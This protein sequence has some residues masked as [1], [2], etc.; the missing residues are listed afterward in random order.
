MTTSRFQ[1][2]DLL[3]APSGF[4]YPQTVRFQDIDAAGIVFF[5]RIFEYCHDAYVAFLAHAG[6]PLPAVL[7]TRAWAAPL[8]H[9]EADFLRPLR[10]GDELRVQ[11]VA[12]ELTGSTLR[13]GYRLALAALRTSSSTGTQ[14]SGEVV[15]VAQTEHVFVAPKT[16]QRI[17]PPPRISDV[18]ARLWPPR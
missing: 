5:S 4:T 9:A 2:E 12:G 1:R 18:M 15:A 10:Y 6:E 14:V 7:L 3:A 11:M 16:F 13:L 8:T 17:A